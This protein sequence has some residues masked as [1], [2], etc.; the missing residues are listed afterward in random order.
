MAN[1]HFIGGE[2]GGIGKSLVARILAQ[3]YIDHA[4]L[5][6]G[7][8]TDKSHGALMRFYAGYASSVVVDRF[9]SMDAIVESALEAP[10]RNILVDLAAQT[11]HALARWIDESGLVELQEESGLAL[12]YWHVMDS[13]RDSV[14]LLRQLLDQFG[15]R[16][17]LVLVLNQIRGENFG[18]LQ[19][20][21][22]LDRALALDAR[23]INIRRLHEGTMTKIDRHSSSFWAASRNTGAHALGILERQRVKLW[24]RAC[25]AE[26]D[27]LDL[28]STPPVAAEEEQIPD[29]A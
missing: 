16:L 28:L 29:H 12:Y 4:Q 11:Q 2:K 14:D 3:Y 23:L 24:L 15:G 7:F 27:T 17:Q 22:E 18:I 5:F 21:G 13:G 9:E 6:L 25:Y 1:I 26:L 19:E 10:E 8:D 20:S